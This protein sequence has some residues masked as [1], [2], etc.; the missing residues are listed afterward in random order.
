VEEE[1]DAHAARL[2]TCGNTQRGDRALSIVGV[3]ASDHGIGHKRHG[4]RQLTVPGIKQASKQ[5]DHL[6]EFTLLL[7]AS[8]VLCDDE[9]GANDVENMTRNLH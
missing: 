6:R 9:V 2:A 8:L 4:R 3:R 1:K 5:S 7:M